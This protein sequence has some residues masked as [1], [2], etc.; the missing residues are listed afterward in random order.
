MLSSRKE[1]GYVQAESVA[2]VS[3]FIMYTLC[4][5]DTPGGA[6]NTIDKYRLYCFSLQTAACT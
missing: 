2:Y 1:T 6:N 5:E 4:Q 3:I